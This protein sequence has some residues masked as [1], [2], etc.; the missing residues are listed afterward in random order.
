MENH[1]GMHVAGVPMR[2][3]PLYINWTACKG[4]HVS[5]VDTHVTGSR[6]KTTI[7]YVNQTEC[8]AT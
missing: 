7:L 2:M 6:M 8:I 1:L 4:T 3:A 5:H